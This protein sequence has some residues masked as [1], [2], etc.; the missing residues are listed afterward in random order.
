MKK[1]SN[2]IRKK[3]V[4]RIDSPQRHPTQVSDKL[5]VSK[6]VLQKYI[7]KIWKI[8]IKTQLGIFELDL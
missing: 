4:K 1:K 5:N 7:S 3:I 6:V 8:T 2:K